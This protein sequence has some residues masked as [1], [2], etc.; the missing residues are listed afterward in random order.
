MTLRGICKLMDPN[1][2]PSV[3][4][5]PKFFLLIKKSEFIFLILSRK[6]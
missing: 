3:P 4:I 5:S 1:L 6:D 2:A